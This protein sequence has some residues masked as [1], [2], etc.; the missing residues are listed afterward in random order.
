LSSTRLQG[1]NRYATAIQISQAAFPESGVSKVFIASGQNFP[2]ALSAGPVAA[3]LDA[4]LLLT[5]P[6][7]LVEDLRL[8]LDRLDPLEIVILGS[9]A[10]VSQFVE[11]ELVGAGWTVT[12]ISGVNRFETAVLTSRLVFQTADSVFVATGTNF[13]DALAGSAAAIN[14]SSPLLLVQ[15][16]STTIVPVVASYLSEL[17]PSRIY[18]LGGPTVVSD[19]VVFAL[20]A[21]GSVERIAGANRIDTSVQIAN[22]FFRSAEGAIVTFGWNFP[23]ALAGSMLA[24]KLGVPILTSPQNCV[25]R[26]VINDFRRLGTNQF[27]VLGSEAALAAPVASL[28][29]CN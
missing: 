17:R 25:T 27:Y 8:E 3:A 6:Q 20:G 26:G 24:S 29:P 14:T 11:D 16:N 10:A 1:A 12:R 19:E 5:H 9:V 23:D 4:P 28:F 7:F 18:V 21:Y 13:P 22:R 2:D 15:G